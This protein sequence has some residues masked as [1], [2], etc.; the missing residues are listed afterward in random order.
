M[1]NLQ[2]IVDWRGVC[3]LVAAEVLTDDNGESG[4]TTGEPFAVAGVAQIEKSTESSSEAKYYDNIAA[5]VVTADG[6]DSLTISTSAL[7]I[8]VLAKLTGQKYDENLGSLIEGPREH[9]YFAIGYKTQKTNGNEMYVWRLKCSVAP[10]NE[11]NSTE[12]N[13]TNSNGQELSVTSIVT[14][15][16][17]TANADA[18]GN[19]RGA[20]SLVVDT[21]KGNADVSTFFDVV[22]TPDTLMPITVA[23]PANVTCQATAD[24]TL[25]IAWDAVSNATHYRIYRYSVAEQDYVF[26]N[27]VEAPTLSYSNTG[28]TANTKYYYKVT[29]AIEADGEIVLESAKSPSAYA[30]AINAPAAPANVAASATG[31]L[32]ITVTYD[33]VSGANYYST[34]RSATST[35]TYEY[36]G[37]NGTGSYVDSD[38]LVAGRTYYYKVRAV[39]NDSNGK[40][41]GPYS[42]AA[43]ATATVG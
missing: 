16:K 19:A 23:T 4:Y 6:A 9:K 24:K 38:N 43:S 15:H 11:S 34:Y 30:T 17:F 5:I 25:T 14:T 26:L 10:P 8:D 12:D 42:S 7:P 29:A 13:S 21:S 41:P 20:K 22:T 36:L 18:K 1:A 35:G 40:V 27:Q 3:D 37:S 28:L 33:T 32:E 39:I 2:E 31:N